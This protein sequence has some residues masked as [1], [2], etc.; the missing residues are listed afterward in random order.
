[1][2][3]DCFCLQCVMNTLSVDQCFFYDKRVV[4]RID[5]DV[6]IHDGKIVSDKK[7]R[8]ALPTILHVLNQGAKSAVLIS[9]LDCPN[10]QPVAQYSLEPVAIKLERLLDHQVIFLDDCVGEQVEIKCADPSPG[11]VF[12][13]ENLRFHHE[14]VGSHI[15]SLG[16][17]TQSLSRLGDI[18]I[19]D[20]FE[21]CHTR[22]SSVV[23]IDLPV[24][25]AGFQVMRELQFFHSFLYEPRR[26]FLAMV[27]GLLLTDKIPLFDHLL[28]LAD[29][30]I[31]AGG[32][33]FT[34][35]KV[36]HGISIGRSVYDEQAASLVPIIVD[37]ARI[38]HIHIHLPR[39]IVVASKFDPLADTRTINMPAGIPD[40][41]IGLDIGVK[42]Q[43]IFADVI[44]RAR[45]ILWH[46]PPGVYEMDSCS[47]GTEQTVKAVV[48]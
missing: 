34:F 18:F 6:P 26:P 19:N 35:L 11:S 32:L 5:F 33:A 3:F 7:I 36:L 4:I 45:T 25:A 21:T 2:M 13:L 15:D 30:I 10:G 9:H 37:R 40:G 27:G 44:G 20:A 12:L 47:K 17:R 38:K 48:K 39:D 41:W 8:D 42:T 16:K 1:S 23:G 22:H 31:I 24:K 43:K 28:D 46:G 29:D 14:E